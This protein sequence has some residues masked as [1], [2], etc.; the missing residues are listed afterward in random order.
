M[1]LKCQSTEII[2]IIIYQPELTVKLLG[3]NC[4]RGPKDRPLAEMHAKWVK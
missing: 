1:L 4:P 2:R 3:D